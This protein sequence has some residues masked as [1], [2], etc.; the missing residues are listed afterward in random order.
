MGSDQTL[1]LREELSTLSKSKYGVVFV[2]KCKKRGA[3]VPPKVTT[4]VLCPFTVVE[5]LSY[6]FAG[7]SLA[8]LAQPSCKHCQHAMFASGVKAGTFCTLTYNTHHCRFAVSAHSSALV[9]ITMCSQ[10]GCLLPP[11][12]S[13][14]SWV[15]KCMSC[16]TI[17]LGSP[18]VVTRATGDTPTAVTEPYLRSPY[19]PPPVR[20]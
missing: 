5:F 15:A 11:D 20:T 13:V 19:H 16:R 12:Q 3:M 1:F 10:G 8:L 7:A 14:V 4:R 17:A 9:K 18:I 2:H 6:L